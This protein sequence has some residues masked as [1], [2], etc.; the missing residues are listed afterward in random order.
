[1]CGRITLYDSPPRYAH[2]LGAALGSRVDEENWRP[3]WNVPPTG[4]LLGA[5]LDQDGV[6]VLDTYRWGLVPGWAKDLGIGNK[7]FNARA[8]TVASKPMFR[9]AFKRQRAVMPVSGFYEWS[10]DSA[11]QP[12]LFE[13]AG[14]GPLVFAGLWERWGSGD[15]ERWTCTVITT[16][17]GPDMPIHHRQPVALSEDQWEP[18]LEPESDPELLQG[19]LV[20]QPA[21]AMT[22]RP[23]GKA[24]G[25]SR[26][27]GPEL[28]APAD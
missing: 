17:A 27:D 10:Q 22:H 14:G 24:V 8:E 15:V 7:A 4:T 2:L 25:N 16:N 21:G 1:M 20:P 3:S 19:L 11:K 5:T 9:S 23:V 13:A 18:W 6:L 12:Y 28:I 26:A